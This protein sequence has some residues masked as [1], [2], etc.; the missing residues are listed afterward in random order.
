MHL[1]FKGISMRFIFF[2]FIATWHVFAFAETEPLVEPIEDE[3][4]LLPETNA[5]DE[6]LEDEAIS[7]L[8]NFSIIPHK[9]NYLLPFSFNDKIQDY[10]IY[11]NNGNTYQR[12]EVKF[13]I[14]FKMPLFHNIGNL[15]ISG[16]VAYT[17]RS[18]WQAYNTASSSP[19]RE[20]NYEPEAFLI[21]DANKE[22]G[23]GW[24]F[25]AASIGFVHQSNGKSEPSSRSWNRIDSS[26]IFDRQNLVISINPW[27]RLEEA[28]S[29]DD[30]PDLL[31]YYGHGKVIIAY[32]H[33]EHVYSFTSQ[34]NIESGF[35]KGS[36]EAA[37]SFPLYG[38]VK[39]YL[40]VTSGYGNSLIEYNEYTNTIGLGI[41]ISDLL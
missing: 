24:R 18:L 33:N 39:G 34:N 25:K 38:K 17:Q 26:F 37:W 31:D 12:L 32:K 36:V 41:S 14:S 19:F 7:E 16:Y 2:V 21:W 11:K 15:P 28:S 3:V 4:T 29:D 35:S 10:D 1:L 23:S 13:Q 27:Y 8:V 20:T 40:Q 30:N 9:P 5:I 6:R 22:L